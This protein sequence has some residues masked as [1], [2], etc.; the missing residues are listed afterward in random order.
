VVLIMGRCTGV[1]ILELDDMPSASG[2]EGRLHADQRLSLLE[3]VWRELTEGEKRTISDRLDANQRD[4]IGASVQITV[5]GHED[6]SDV[7]HE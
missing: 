5:G 3:D 7:A 6:W 2:P 4:V 1:E